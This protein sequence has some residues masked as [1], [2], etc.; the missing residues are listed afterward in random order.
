MDVHRW[1]GLTLVLL[2]GCTITRN[3]ER[4]PHSLDSPLCVQE[5]PTVWSKEFLPALCE[6]IERH[7]VRTWVYQTDRPADCRYHVTYVARWRWDMATY[8]RYADIQVF[9]DER[10]IGRALYDASGGTANPCKFGS[11]RRKLRSLIDQLMPSI[12]PPPARS[13]S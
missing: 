3:V 6:E 1:I 10:L 11:T 5:N 4:V 2:A 9:E 7:G 13:T 8:L 12:N